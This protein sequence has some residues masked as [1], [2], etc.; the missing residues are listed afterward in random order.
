ML[1]FK[2]MRRFDVI[3]ILSSDSLIV[4]YLFHGY[5]AHSKV[6][7]RPLHSPPASGVHYAIIRRHL[8][9]KSYKYMLY[10]WVGTGCCRRPL[11]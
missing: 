1:V 8:Y 5:I 3:K 2:N 11:L 6:F 9:R 4:I 7:C 10:F